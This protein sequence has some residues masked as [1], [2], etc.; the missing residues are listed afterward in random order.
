MFGHRADVALHQSAGGFFR[1]AERFLDRGAVV[2]LH[3]LEDRL[4]LVL[5]EVLDQRDRVVGLEL[6]GDVRDLL[7][8]HLVEE[9]LAH[10]IVE[11]GQHVGADDPGQR[12]DQALA[13]VG[14][15]E[16]DQIGDVGRVERPDQRPRGLV[17]TGL[18]SV[19]HFLD[20]P[21]TEV[22]FLVHHG[23]RRVRLYGWRG[24]DVI[25]LAHSR[26]PRCDRFG[27]PMV[28]AALAQPSPRP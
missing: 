23:V 26:F 10:I 1:V 28:V 18:D 2:R 19:E 25:A 15:G 8:L 12:L 9:A 13:L 5:V 24:G 21:R 17:I 20:E 16:L 4:L 27:P 6:A 14:A 7:R 3:P 11:L 22:G